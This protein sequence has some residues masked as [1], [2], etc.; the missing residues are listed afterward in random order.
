MNRRQFLKSTAC[1]LAV[2]PLAGALASAAG[3]DRPNILWITVE[4]MSPT[5]GCYGDKYAYTP[6][7]DRLSSQSVR[8]KHVYANAPVC[9]PA[10]SS[11]ITGVFA[12]SLGT[13]HLRGVMP[14]SDRIKG[15]PEYLRRAGYY[16]T[17]NV[18]EDYNFK[19][20]PTFWDES[21]DTAHWRKG[22]KR[23]PFFSIFNLM[24][25]HQSR[26]RYE[27]DELDKVNKTLPAAARRDPAR[28]PLPPY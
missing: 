9:T 20:P 17:N 23:K 21:S 27:Q 14:L 11:I 6:N 5:L 28:A 8:Y 19:T 10:R 16:C 15:Y 3:E 22:P 7:I 24:T 13:Q 12:S 4:D 1:S 25:T 18:K 2:A 26:T